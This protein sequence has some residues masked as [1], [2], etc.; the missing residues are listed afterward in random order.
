M[1]TSERKEIL[2]ID[3]LTILIFCTFIMNVVAGALV[4]RWYEMEAFAQ[5]KTDQDARAVILNDIRKIKID[6][7]E[8]EGVANWN[9]TR[10][11]AD[12]PESSDNEKI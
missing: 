5:R 9:M 10:Y 4:W 3:G 2:V 11:V 1:S 12:H 7:V 8:R 6:I